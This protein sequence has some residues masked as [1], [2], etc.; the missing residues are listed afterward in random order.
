MWH[1]LPFE[2]EEGWKSILGWHDCVDVDVLISQ[3]GRS[4]AVRDMHSI[5]ETLSYLDQCH[6]AEDYANHLS[7]LKFIRGTDGELANPANVCRQGVERLI[8]YLHTVD[9]RFCDDHSKIMKLTNVPDLPQ[10][11]QLRRVQKVLE[12]RNAL[13]EKDLNVAIGLACIWGTHFSEATDGLK[14]PNSNG[15]LVDIADLVF[16]DVPSL[17]DT[18]RHILHPKIS[19]TTAAQLKVE[20]LSE[21]MRK[22]D[23]GI[24]DPDDDDEFYQREEITDGIRDTLDRYT[25]EHTF[26]E[27]LANADDCG[28]ASEV[29]FFFDGTTYGTTHLLSED[30]QVLQGPSLLIHNDGSEYHLLIR[31]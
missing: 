29:N 25:R 6:Q 19:R 17:S 26:H 15:A 7:E 30:L 13:D 14:L 9:P 28:S 21:S 2:I 10:L 8:P 20:P 1:V 23:L 3:L 22:G 11:E 16:P 5:D 18:T 12:S 24:A 31:T 4:I 27:Y